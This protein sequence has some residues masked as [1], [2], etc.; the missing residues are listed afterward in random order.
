MLISGHTDDVGTEAYNMSLGGKRA[1]AVYGFLINYGVEEARLTTMSFGEEKPKSAGASDA[2]RE[3]NRRAH[4][5]VEV[6]K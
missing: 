2:D 6:S 5:K 4:F 1:K 3:L